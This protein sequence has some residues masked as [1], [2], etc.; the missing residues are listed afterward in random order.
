[1]RSH[2]QLRRVCNPA[3]LFEQ[4][5]DEH[6]ARAVLA[7][8]NWAQEKSCDD[9]IPQRV[10]LRH[11][12]TQGTVRIEPSYPETTGYI[13]NTIAFGHGLK[14]PTLEKD[15][16]SRL[17]QY[18]LNCQLAS[19][20]F[21]PPGTER[22]A[23]AFD[24]GQA[25]TGLCAYDRHVGSTPEVQLAIER[26]A[27]WLAQ[28]ITEDGS[29]DVAACYQG[30]R[31]YYIR[32]TIGLWMAARLLNNAAWLEAA[33][34][35]A[36]WTLSQRIGSHW[37]EHISFEDGSFQNLHGIAYTIRGLVQLGHH[38]SLPDCLA[39][40]R[41]LLDKI[42]MQD[43]QG[44]VPA[45]AIPGHFSANFS[46]YKKTV[47]PTGMCQIAIS[48]YMLAALYDEPRYKQFADR[49]VECVKQFQFSGFS[50]PG[51]NG[52]LPGSWP[53]T[54]PY[55][56]CALPNWPAKFFLDC[57]YIRMGANPLELGG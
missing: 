24:T 5:S 13:L 22:T 55:M 4:Q 10:D 11:A 45:H 38:C 46:G 39:L 15:N 8:L 44:L 51:L 41:A 48:A 50:E 26:A 21:P 53:V 33:K 34:K 36:V 32:A 1:M 29:Y 52:L 37:L 9:G 40:G 35:N 25:L 30:Q 3:H 6:H 31:A 2:P 23:L 14:L 20:G 43:Y 27:Q 47:S 7:W 57:L 17:V 54:G 42:M 19:G 49:L 56:H 18:L 28:Q 16:I 12:A